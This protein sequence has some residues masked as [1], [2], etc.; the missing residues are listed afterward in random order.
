[1]KNIETGTPIRKK[2]KIIKLID[3]ATFNSLHET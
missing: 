1:V 2:K 3:H